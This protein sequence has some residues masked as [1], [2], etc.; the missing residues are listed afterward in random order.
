M[1]NTH[2]YYAFATRALAWC[3]PGL[4][5]RLANQCH[6]GHSFTFTSPRL[7]QCS[8]YRPRPVTY[9]WF[10][11][12]SLQPC[13]RTEFICITFFSSFFFLAGEG[14]GRVSVHSLQSCWIVLGFCAL[15]HV[16]SWDVFC[17]RKTSLGVGWRSRHAQDLP[18]WMLHTISSHVLLGHQLL[19]PR[20]IQC[21]LSP[22]FSDDHCIQTEWTCR[23]PLEIQKKKSQF[24]FSK[25]L[26]C[27]YFLCIYCMWRES[28]RQFSANTTDWGYKG[29]CDM[30]ISLS[31]LLA[32]IVVF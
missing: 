3:P 12:A 30:F 9:S 14:R 8:L 5:V 4:S 24:F 15:Y 27:D 31:H 16:H 13:L 18:G 22:L 7:H 25:P 11:W 26:S 28:H 32:P 21:H 23:T 6:G 2:T 29:Q 19:A 20:G 1:L 17:S 10:H